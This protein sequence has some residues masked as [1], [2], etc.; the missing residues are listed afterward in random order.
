MLREI[1]VAI[2]TVVIFFTA[3]TILKATGT[4]RAEVMVGVK[5]TAIR[6]V[7]SFITAFAAFYTASAA[8]T[9]VD[10]RI[11]ASAFATEVTNYTAFAASVATSTVTA[12]L[13]L[14]IEIVTLHTICDE[15][16]AGTTIRTSHTSRTRIAVIGEDNTALDTRNVSFLTFATVIAASTRRAEVIRIVYNTAR[17]TRCAIVTLAAASTIPTG[18]AELIRFTLKA[19]VSAIE[20]TLT[21]IHTEQTVIAKLFPIYNRMTRAADGFIVGYAGNVVAHTHVVVT[22][23][24]NFVTFSKDST[25]AASAFFVCRVLTSRLTANLT[26]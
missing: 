23:G 15:R 24:T 18:S 2:S 16:S 13:R 4:I 19:T 22:I 8:I 1:T 25:A 5:E 3:R 20:R 10:L 21:A 17:G 26:E 14:R 6:T 12:N 7:L 11:R 9:E